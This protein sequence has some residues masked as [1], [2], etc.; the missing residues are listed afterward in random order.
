MK[1]PKAVKTGITKLH[2]KNADET[3]CE[4]S[5]GTW[6]YDGH[7]EKTKGGLALKPSWLGGPRFTTETS[8]EAYE[9]KKDKRRQAFER[10]AVVGAKA[11]SERPI[12]NSAEAFEFLV[13][14]RMEVALS[15]D[16]G[17]LGDAKWID[18][19]LHGNVKKDTPTINIRIDNA[20]LNAI[21]AVEDRHIIEGEFEEI[22]DEI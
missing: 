8:I 3:I 20:T 21:Q 11:T 12:N 17:S 14:K 6:R 4:Y 7:G 16:A 2:P 19:A 9:A 1:K 22:G 13:E 15:G 10:G 18:E 5:D